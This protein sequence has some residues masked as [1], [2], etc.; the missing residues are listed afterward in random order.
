MSTKV[1]SHMNLVRVTGLGISYTN[2]K[3]FSRGWEKLEGDH[4]KY[5]VRIGYKLARCPGDHGFNIGCATCLP[6]HGAVA[7]FTPDCPYCC[8]NPSPLCPY[9]KH[10]R[11]RFAILYPEIPVDHRAKSSGAL[12]TPDRNHACP[13]CEGYGVFANSKKYWVCPRCG[14]ARELRADG[15]PEVRP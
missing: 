14:G 6:Y 4:Q 5:L 10:V 3:G 7:I 8:D 15:K 12:G 1:P 9:C 13:E 2:L 11:A